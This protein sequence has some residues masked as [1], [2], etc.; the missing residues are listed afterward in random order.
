MN[1]VG[2]ATIRTR[3]VG[4]AALP[5]IR[6]GPSVASTSQIA[7]GTRVPGGVDPSI[8]EPSRDRDNWVLDDR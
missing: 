6:A 7:F 4:A 8:A 3:V 5:R 2:S 1:E